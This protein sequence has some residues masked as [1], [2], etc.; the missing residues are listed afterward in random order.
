MNL[1]TLIAGSVG[2]GGKNHAVDVR[3]VQ[4]LLND[5]LAKTGQIQ[6]KVDGM[7]GPKTLGA[8]SS[9]QKKNTSSRDGRVD[10]DGPTIQ[11]LLNVHLAGLLT[12]IDLSRLSSY[13]NESAVKNTPTSEPTIA[14]II[15]RYITALRESA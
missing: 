13:F 12:S 4:R 6:L 15:K 10:V 11:A 9:F 1:N 5:W 8:I 3:I 7:V 2:Q 14:A